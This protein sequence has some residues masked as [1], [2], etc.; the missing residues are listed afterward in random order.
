MKIFPIYFAL[1]QFR[2]YTHS[3]IIIF[4]IFFYLCFCRLFVILKHI[5][6][7]VQICVLNKHKD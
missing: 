1:L 5:K 6:L 4:F 3:I 7:F 2:F